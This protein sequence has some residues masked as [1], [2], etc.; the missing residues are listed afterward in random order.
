VEPCKTPNVPEN[1]KKRGCSLICLQS[2][3]QIAAGEIWGKN[4]RKLTEFAN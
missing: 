1:A 3:W 4:K 2:M